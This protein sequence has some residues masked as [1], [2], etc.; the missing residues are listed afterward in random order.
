MAFECSGVVS[1]SQRVDQA[2]LGVTVRV[3]LVGCQS[4]A[5]GSAR[6]AVTDGL[7][8]RDKLPSGR[9]PLLVLRELLLFLRG[10]LLDE[11]PSRRDQCDNEQDGKDAS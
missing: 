4:E 9:K 5:Y 10:T 7:G 2:E 8:L 3:N 1:R 6:I 11:R